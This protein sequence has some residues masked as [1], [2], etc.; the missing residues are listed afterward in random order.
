MRILENSHFDYR[1][2]GLIGRS[3]AMKKHE[4]LAE[5]ERHLRLSAMDALEVLRNQ[6]GLRDEDR[7]KFHID[8]IRLPSREKAGL[9]D[10]RFN[11]PVRKTICCVSLPTATHF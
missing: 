1:L 10:V 2:R 11:S 9:V 7:A 5:S 3:L 8:L 6:A 4:R